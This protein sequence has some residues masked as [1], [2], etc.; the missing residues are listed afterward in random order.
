MESVTETMISSVH[1]ATPEK[2]L[3]KNSTNYSDDEIDFEVDF[4]N[5]T[6]FCSCSCPSFKRER[7][8]CK[9]F[10]AVFASRKTSYTDLSALFKDH[11]YVTLDA[12]LFNGFDQGNATEVSETGKYF[13]K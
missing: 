5:D 9:H 2:F 10:F 6:R 11:P 3:V 12:D 8:I 1:Q 4:G 7:M 13:Y